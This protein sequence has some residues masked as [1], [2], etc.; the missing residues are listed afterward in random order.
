MRKEEKGILEMHRP[1][2]SNTSH[3]IKGFPYGVCKKVSQG[4]TRDRVR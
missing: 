4:A 3:K 2:Q 1:E